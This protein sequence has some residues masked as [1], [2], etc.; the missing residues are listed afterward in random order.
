MERTNKAEELLQNI[1]RSL[2]EVAVSKQHL[3]ESIQK[4]NEHTA[5]T[6]TLLAHFDAAV[7]SGKSNMNKKLRSLAEKARE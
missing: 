5:A 4:I 2:A 3:S 1:N 6:H 7:I